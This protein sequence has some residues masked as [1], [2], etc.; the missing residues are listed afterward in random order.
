MKNHNEVNND[1]ESM[2]IRNSSEIFREESKKIGAFAADFTKNAIEQLS[3]D[4][5][6]NLPT[7]ILN[8]STIKN[9]A[10]NSA[11]VSAISSMLKWDIT[12]TMEFCADLLE[13]VNAHTEAAEMRKR[14]YAEVA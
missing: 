4:V 13:D 1:L 10:L 3:Y 8:R 14:A 12:E 7:G 6:T 9:H 5:L 2:G 11:I